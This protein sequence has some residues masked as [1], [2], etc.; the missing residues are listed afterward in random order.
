MTLSE[1]S[2]LKQQVVYNL[3]TCEKHNRILNQ[4]KN[5]YKK[6]IHSKRRFEQINTI[7][8]LLRIL[9]IREVLSE[10]NVSPLKEIA[11]LL[12][13]NDLLKSI[14]EYELTHVP[15]TYMNYYAHHNVSESES[16]DSIPKGHPYGNISAR[17]KARINETIVEEIG[18]YWRDLARNLKIQENRIDEI[19]TQKYTL[20]DKARELLK[21]Y[22]HK[23]DPQRG[24]YVLCDALEKARRKDLSKNLQEIMVMNI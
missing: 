19:D 11:C 8:Q 15:R 14:S 24:F 4:L 3:G 20:T 16:I 12:Q 7:G 10:D 2:K 1:Y 21:I 18:T 23:A 6:D 5:L 22:Q 17:K 13:S 9:E